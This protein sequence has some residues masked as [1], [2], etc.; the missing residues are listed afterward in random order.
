MLQHTAS[1]K[2]DLLFL[3]RAFFGKL[4][5][6]ARQRR[7]ILQ[8]MSSSELTS[9]R[10]GERRALLPKL[11]SQLKQNGLEDYRTHIQYTEIMFDGV[12]LDCCTVQCHEKAALH[13]VMS[14]S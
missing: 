6:L 7:D 1:Q 8:R 13:A 5:Q 11:S 4:V 3:R 9:L 14:F 10:D 2:E 12:C